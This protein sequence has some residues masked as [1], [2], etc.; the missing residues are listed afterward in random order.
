MKLVTLLPF[1]DPII[2]DALNDNVMTQGATLKVVFSVAYYLKSH[3]A[4][5]LS[6]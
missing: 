4:I 6:Y 5:S 1:Q 2:I 3:N